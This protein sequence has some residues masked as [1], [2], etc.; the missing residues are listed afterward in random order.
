MLP[1]LGWLLFSACDEPVVE[2]AYEPDPVDRQLLVEKVI[3]IPYSGITTDSY[4]QCVPTISGAEI[5]LEDGTPSLEISYK[6]S[7]LGSGEVLGEGYVLQ[8]SSEMAGPGDEIECRVYASDRTGDAA[9][10]AAAVVVERALRH[11]GEQPLYFHGHRPADELGTSIATIGDM[12]GDG[13]PD[14]ALGAPSSDSSFIDAGKVYVMTAVESEIEAAQISFIGETI[15]DAAGTSVGS[16]GDVDG[17]GLADILVGAPGYDGGALDSGKAYLFFGASLWGGGEF[18]LDEA[19][20][21]FV[22]T[23]PF[24]ELGGAA[25]GAGDMDGDGF[26]DV[27]VGA[28]SNRD[29]GYHAGKVSLY[30]GSSL[31]DGAETADYVFL[32]EESYARLGSRFLQAGDVDGDGLADLWISAPASSSRSGKLY[33][34]TGSMLLAQDVDVIDAPCILRAEAAGDGMGL[35]FD[36]GDLDGDGTPDIAIGSP[37]SE[38]SDYMAGRVDILYSSA[39]SGEVSLADAGATF[40]GEAADDRA[41]TG[42]AVLSDFSG[43]GRADLLVGAPG[44]SQADTAAGKVYIVESGIFS[45]GGQHEL[46]DIQDSFLGEAAHDEAGTSIER[47]GDIDGDSL[48]DFLLSAPRSNGGG[49]D[50][51][52][53]YVIMGSSL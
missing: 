23:D 53:V 19:D 15:K 52:T 30:L 10:N 24:E 3:V 31:F 6:W 28:P 9:E 22:G 16:A 47:L 45:E 20:F 34:V 49:S 46:A 36:A 40:L 13:D 32:G 25:A 41:G 11:L 5:A 43:D 48:D 42:L 33:L 21:S 7:N 35:A 14:F 27:V 18:G 50:S 37:H 8:L 2:E 51:G 12:N 44:S 1:L 29:R 4:L 17:D 38:S 39:L 26:G